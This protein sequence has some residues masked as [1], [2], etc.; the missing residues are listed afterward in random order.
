MAKVRAMENG[1]IALPFS[2]AFVM[3]RFENFQSSDCKIDLK[4]TLLLRVKFTDLNKVH[5]NRHLEERDNISMS[6]SNDHM[7][8]VI[9]HVR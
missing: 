3:K 4:M 6:V 8:D 1:D 7:I 2:V 5:N 9:N